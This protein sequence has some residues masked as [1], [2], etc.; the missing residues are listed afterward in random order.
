MSRDFVEMERVYLFG[1]LCFFFLRTLVAIEHMRTKR[2]TV[3][4]YAKTS[5]HL[6]AKSY[7]GNII[8]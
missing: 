6:S 3:F 4:I 8:G 5:H 1:Q 7:S 2:I